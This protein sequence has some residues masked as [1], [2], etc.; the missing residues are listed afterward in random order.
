MS[1][2]KSDNP[3]PA[4]NYVKYNNP[5]YDKY[6]KMAEATR[7][8]DKKIEYIQKA[9]E[10]FVEDAPVWFFNYN[11][12]IMAHHPW[13]HGLAAVAP[14]MMFQDM[15]SVWVDENSPRANRK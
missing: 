4:G 5:E 11:K 2:W 14:E 13:V 9:E 8:K 10:I 6:I 3:P 15:T 7:D 12:A 1:R